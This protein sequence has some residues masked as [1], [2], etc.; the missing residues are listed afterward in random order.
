MHSVCTDILVSYL[1]GTYCRI[2][3]VWTL[4]MR[5]YTY[6]SLRGGG[7]GLMVMWV[8]NPLIL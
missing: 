2:S 6:V 3:T 8:L 7:Q 4:P 5:V 1:L